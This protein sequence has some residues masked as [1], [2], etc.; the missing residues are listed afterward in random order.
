MTDQLEPAKVLVDFAQDLGTC[1]SVEAV[2]HHLSDRCMSLL[3]VA[4]VGVLLAEDGDLTVAT[5]NSE[6]GEVAERL[7]VELTEGPCI[8]ALRSGAVV[9]VPDL[10][11]S[12]D[13][14]PKFAPA[15][16]DAGVGSIHGLPLS[17]R[18][19]MVGVLNIVHTEPLDLPA[20]DIATT[21]MLADVAVSYILSVRMHE[22]SSRLASQL[23]RAL[24]TRVVIEQAK[25]V[26]AERHGVT[27]SDAFE[28]LRRHAR[29]NNM[30]VRDV[31]ADVLAGDL[32]L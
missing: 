6:V 18:G 27:M 14:Y 22:E 2:L 15:A 11:R 28:R 30:T 19:E 16:L 29:S 21:Q 31:A 20:A 9:I 4:G 7:E 32:K 1:A 23:Q 24:D 26:L 17:G 5:T 8:E 25:G 12:V 10:R 3:S 13:R